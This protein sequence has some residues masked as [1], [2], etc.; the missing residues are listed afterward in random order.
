MSKE[1]PTILEPPAGDPYRYRVRYFDHVGRQRQKT[2]SGEDERTGRQ[3]LKAAEAFRDE[4]IGK[5]QRGERTIASKT[6]VDAFFDEWW[7][8]VVDTPRIADGTANGSYG[9]AFQHRILPYMGTA[10]IAS[11]DGETID[12]FVAWMSKKGVGAQT[13]RN[14][15]TALSSM[16][17]TAVKWKRIPYNPCHGVDL[18]LVA[19]ADRRAYDMETVY[20]IA[21]GMRFDRDRALVV[22]AA[23][24]GQRKA[25][26]YALTWENVDTGPLDLPDGYQPQIRVFRKKSQKWG[27][28]PLFEPARLALLWLR[29]STPFPDGADY[30]FPSSTGTSLARQ[31]STHY[32]RHWR[33]GCVMAGLVRCANARCRAEVPATEDAA[34]RVAL[35]P[36]RGAKNLKRWNDR[37]ARGEKPRGPKPEEPWAC[38]RC[39]EHDVVGPVFHELR[40]TFGSHAVYATGDLAQVARW[41][42]WSST[43]ML[44]RRYNHQLEQGQR[45]AVSAM[46][47]LAGE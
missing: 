42:G 7:E 33:S 6:T 4:L 2:Y 40:H 11:I 36:K 14:T 35:D 24:T 8:N 37:V 10:T 32:R 1:R 15:V 45:Q 17:Q 26:L 39:G 22:V 21:A 30:V 41:G 44:E 19:D 29:A 31:A 23:W 3:A 28:V 20:D 46:N 18:P 25:D 12:K 9:P 16:L 34:R 13:I 27:D 47:R 38:P 43:T 5:T